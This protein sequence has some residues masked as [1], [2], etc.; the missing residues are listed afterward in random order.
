MAKKYVAGSC[1]NQH[2][3]EVV[4]KLRDAGPEVYDFRNPS[5]SHG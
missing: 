4:T 3:P 5:H 2:D 1:R